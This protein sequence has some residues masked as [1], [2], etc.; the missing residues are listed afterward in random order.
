M[1]YTLYDCLISSYRIVST[2]DEEPQENI[3]LS[4]SRCEITYK[5]HDS[6]HETGNPQRTGYD[7]AKAA[8]L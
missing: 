5:D 1:E 2:G 6:T 7:L 8:P 4:F 3:S